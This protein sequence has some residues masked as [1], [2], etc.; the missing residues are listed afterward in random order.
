[1]TSMYRGLSY[2]IIVCSPY[3]AL[4]PSYLFLSA[5]GLSRVSSPRL[6]SS[7]PS[8]LLSPRVGVGGR[9]TL[10]A[11]SGLWVDVPLRPPF[12]LITQEKGGLTW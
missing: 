11:M 12:V 5:F 1:M 8:L 9:D 10:H 6:S 2:N 7:P 3:I 4:P